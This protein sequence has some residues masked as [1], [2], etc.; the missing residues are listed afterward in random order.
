MPRPRASKQLRSGSCWCCD[1]EGGRHQREA[2]GA[3][4]GAEQTD[5]GAGGTAASPES[6]DFSPLP[7][8]PG[9]GVSPPRRRR[10]RPGLCAHKATPKTH[11]CPVA[12][13]PL[14]TRCMH[15]EIKQEQMGSGPSLGAPC[16]P[17]PRD[18]RTGMRWTP[19]AEV[20]GNSLC[21]ADFR[22]VSVCGSPWDATL[23]S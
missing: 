13:N 6:V 12:T 15:T 14:C 20:W 23:P 19:R 9:G 5:G 16:L 7:A 10:A 2:R 18:G 4:G 22:A 21:P 8:T 3:L 17:V 1:S 11:G